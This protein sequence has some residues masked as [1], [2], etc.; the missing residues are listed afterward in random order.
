MFVKKNASR[1]EQ[2]MKIRAKV[3]RNFHIGLTG[4]AK[5]WDYGKD[6]E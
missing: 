4:K 3:Q 6:Q 1:R 2:I 5:S